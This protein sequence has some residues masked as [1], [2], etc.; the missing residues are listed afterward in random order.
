MRKLFLLVGLFMLG[1]MLFAPIAL[2]Q[3]P[4]PDPDFPRQ[5][6]DGCQ[7]SNLPDVTP[8]ASASGSAS[9]SP[10]ASASPTASASA[11]AS[12]TASASASPLPE[13]GGP[14]SLIAL[15]PL[16]LLVGSGI[17]AFRLARRR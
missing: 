11:S 17:L 14:V 8:G 5:T 2:A 9:G 13:T 4:C 7:A 12:A 6:P 1:A 16:A 15:A 3:D 10:S